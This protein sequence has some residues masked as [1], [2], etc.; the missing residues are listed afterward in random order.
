MLLILSHIGSENHIGKRYY[1]APNCHLDNQ[2]NITYTSL[3][4]MLTPC[5][6]WI[7]GMWSGNRRRFPLLYFPKLHDLGRIWDNQMPWT[8]VEDENKSC[9]HDKN[10][11]GSAG[12]VKHCYTDDDKDVRH[13]KAVAYLRALY[14]NTEDAKLEANLILGS[15][16]FTAD[17]EDPR[18]LRFKRAVLAR[19][20]VNGNNDSVTEDGLKEVSSTLVGTGIDLEHAETD[21][22]GYFTAASV[23]P[24]P[25]FDNVPTLFVDG[26]LWR[27]RLESR[28]IKP[29]QIEDGTYKLSIEADARE[30]ECS[31]CHKTFEN[32]GEYCDH[33]KTMAHKLRS[34]AV[35]ILRGLRGM[36]GALTKRPAGSSAGFARS[37]IYMIA[38]HQDVA[39]MHMDD[40]D[41]NEMECSDAD[42]FAI[43]ARMMEEP[44]EEDMMMGAAGETP[45]KPYGDVKYAD[46][47]YQKDKKKRYPIDN[48]RHIRAAWN[49]IHK[50]KNA[51]KY[52]AEHAATMIRKIAAAWKRV[53][54]KSGPPGAEKNKKEAN[55]PEDVVQVQAADKPGGTDTPKVEEP[56]DM[57]L[58]HQVSEMDATIKD[59]TAQLDAAKAE[60][61]GLKSQLRASKT[62]LL[63]SQL[64]GSVI[65][66]EEFGKQLEDLLNTPQS[67]I[68]LMLKPRKDVERVRMAVA[69]TEA[70]VDD[71]EL[72]V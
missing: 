31:V 17:E 57:G 42:F 36:G 19:A 30:A 3:S 32:S 33:I 48:E 62:E 43:M 69:A 7:W 45:K 37:T 20:E 64:V 15:I 24:A 58:Q 13:K 4:V 59:M 54:D 2:L 66:E 53:I 44:D 35:R 9:V 55:M 29:E 41:I 40:D 6:E 8:L 11:D 10:A 68:K 26:V 27:H 39:D 71:E 52:S 16:K 56:K 49:Y 60:S 18:F 12:A 21:N 63:R 61:E 65:T 50:A 47:G 70:V 23:E 14:V 38:S 1:D 5:R 22:Y 72:T 51:A 25:D 28:G 34:G 67:A 46:P